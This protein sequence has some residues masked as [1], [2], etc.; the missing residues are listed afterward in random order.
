M[1]VE[2]V[3]SSVAHYGTGFVHV[4]SV[5]RSAMRIRTLLD[6]YELVSPPADQKEASDG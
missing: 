6:R 2:S 3:D 4:R 5:R 1:T